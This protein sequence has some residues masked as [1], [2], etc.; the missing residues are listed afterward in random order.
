MRACTTCIYHLCFSFPD[1]NLGCL[2]GV[3]DCGEESAM[4]IYRSV[5]FDGILMPE[6]TQI[7][8]ASS[9]DA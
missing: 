1:C 7:R 2:G 5:V 4:F 3:L 9:D 8:T 6:I